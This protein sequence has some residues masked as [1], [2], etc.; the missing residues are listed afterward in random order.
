MHNLQSQVGVLEV[1]ILDVGCY[2]RGTGLACSPCPLI[3]TPLIETCFLKPNKQHPHRCYIFISLRQNASHT[4]LSSPH[5]LN[6]TNPSPKMAQIFCN[7]IYLFRSVNICRYDIHVFAHSSDCL[8][9]VGKLGGVT[10]SS[11]SIL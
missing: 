6:L 3:A 10:T 9:S 1:T 8:F 5:R 7:L 11:L 2:V 4:S